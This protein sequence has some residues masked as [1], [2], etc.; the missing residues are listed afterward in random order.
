MTLPRHLVVFAKA[1]RLGRVKS[2]L[3]A[4]IGAVAAWAFYRRTLA[5]VLRRLEGRDGWRSWLA[6]TP[7]DWV[8]RRALRPAGWHVIPQGKGD[9]G[10]RMDRAMRAL[11]PGPV[12]I[13]GTDIPGLSRRHVEAAFDALGRHAAVFGPAVDGGY[14]LVGHRRRPRLPRLFE[15]VRWSTEHAL[16]DTLANLGSGQAAFRLETLEDVDDGAALARWMGAMDGV[17]RDAP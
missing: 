13:V 17:R 9:L 8:S 7:D 4:D 11:P 16:A 10:Q 6:V 1:P 15:N 14:W 5:A 12:V 3:A 2:R